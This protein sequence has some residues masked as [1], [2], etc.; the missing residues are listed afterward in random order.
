MRMFE[1]C[2]ALKKVALHENLHSIGERAFFGCSS[3]DFIIIP[4]SV[5]SIGQD[6]FSNTDKQ[7]IIQ[8]SFGSYAE[9]YARKN[10]I[11][12]QLV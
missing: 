5:K 3:L 11:K 8:C 9:E 2:I 1:E 12:Y 4:D 7:F 6:A 10:K